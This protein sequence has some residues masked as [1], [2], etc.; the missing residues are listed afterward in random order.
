MINLTINNKRITVKEGTTILEA[1]KLNN[2][3][4][5][6]LCYLEGVHKYGSCRICAV[7][8][9]GARNLQAS[10]ITAVREDMVVHTK[11]ERVQK[12]RKLLYELM[13]SDHPKDCLNCERNQSCELQ[14]LGELIQVKEV[15]FNGQQSKGVLDDLSPSIMRDTSKCILCRRCITVCN[16]IQGV[17]VLNAQQRGFKTMIGPAAALQLNSV[18]CAFCGQCTV[19]CPVGALQEKDAITKVWNALHDTKKR[20]IVQ[21]APAIRAA[22]GEEF[23]YE[24]GTLVTG[25]MVT[26]L[27][28]MG[29]DDVFDTNFAADL[30]ILEE[31]NEFLQRI[32]QVFNGS[33]AVL[34]MI[35]S[36]S[37]GW[38]KFV[39]HAFPAE[40]DHLSTCKSP[41][42]MLGALAKSYYAEK[43]GIRP[44]DIFVVSIMP[45]TAKKFEVTRPEL[46]NGG[47]ANVDAVLTTR[48]LARMI[49][50]A[51]I[52][53]RALAESDFDN[54]LGLSTGAADIFGVTGG[55][56]EAALR[57]V[58]EIITGRELPFDGL[59]VHPIVGLERIKTADLVIE[60][61]LPEYKFLGGVTVKVAVTSGLKG[62]K[63]LMEQIAQ[64][65]SPY[66]FIEVMGCPGGCI[67]GGG[68]PRPTTAEIRRKRL[69]AIYQEDE[70]KQLR[71]SH[72]NPL[73]QSLYAEFLGHP[74]GH[75]S[76]EL[77][78][79]HYTDR[80]IYNEHLPTKRDCLG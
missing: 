11:T 42:M 62:A 30:T 33:S 60:N 31:G 63:I 56:M 20:V 25:K 21:T 73:I 13:L 16:E 37:P 79:T 59:H 39:E 67:S 77:L 78:H 70:G 35:T 53:F 32:Q 38:V 46:T 14:K 22:L 29:F 49:K 76:H 68:Q 71:K 18:N 5:P 6:S 51:G 28:E 17:G 36:C 47:Q 50:E 74:L 80:G 57:S 4:I 48:E 45:C 61:P 40:L 55:V 34:P 65:E 54:P 27:R 9:E 24:P 19:V 3:L 72:E 8:V 23:S 52:D 2:I 44:E 41:H 12:A 43:V 75:K 69:A 58:Y 64:G 1:A 7:E 15:R 10:C 66:H 26:A